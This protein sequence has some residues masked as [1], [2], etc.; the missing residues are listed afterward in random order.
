MKKIL[1]TILITMIVTAISAFKIFK[2]IVEEDEPRADRRE[3]INSVILGEKRELLIHLPAGYDPA[4]SYPVMYVLD[5]SSQDFRVAHV[6]EILDRANTV[7]K[8]IIVG[9]PNTRL[10]NTEC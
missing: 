9:I 1:L 4:Q 8:M 6:A 3:E 2:I 5:G 10:I 7:P